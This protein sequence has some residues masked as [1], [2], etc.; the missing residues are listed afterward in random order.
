MRILCLV[1][2]V[3]S[4]IPSASARTGGA[5]IRDWLRTSYRDVILPS[6]TPAK[7]A[8]RIQTFL[9][10]V[11]PGM[12]VTQVLT[13][14]GPPDVWR[15]RPHGRLGWVDP[16]NGILQYSAEDASF[17][18][19]PRVVAIYFDAHA[20]VDK[21]VENGVV[22]LSAEPPSPFERFARRVFPRRS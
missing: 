13:L 3:V 2:A 15:T 6:T 12:S 10:A 8:Q 20:R 4:V 1:L 9:P 17:K 5:D 7:R 19:G 21:I 11:L 18:G 14:L 16:G 22:I